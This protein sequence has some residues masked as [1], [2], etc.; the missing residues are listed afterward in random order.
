MKLGTGRPFGPLALADMIGLDVCLAMMDVLLKDFGDSKYR[1][2][3]AAA[4]RRGW[5]PWQEIM[6][7]CLHTIEK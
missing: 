5:S 2:A 6:L 4:T 1:A 3:R 7:Q